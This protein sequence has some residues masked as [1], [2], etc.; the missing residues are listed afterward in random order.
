MVLYGSCPSVD[1]VYLFMS[2]VHP[3]NVRRYLTRILIE[4]NASETSP[5]VWL[6]W[7]MRQLM[8]DC[9]MNH[10]YV[11]PTWFGC[12]DFLFLLDTPNPLRERSQ[13]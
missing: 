1:A 4:L 8:Q 2:D 7:S 11:P 5:D 10:S 13:H 9:W 3:D 12:G 6:R